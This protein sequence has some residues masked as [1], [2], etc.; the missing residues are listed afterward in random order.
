MTDGTPEALTAKGMAKD[1][2]A[3]VVFLLGTA[4]IEYIKRHFQV[5]SGFTGT[6][7]LLSELTLMGFAAG[8]ALRAANYL[9][10]EFSSLAGRIA[11]DPNLPRLKAGAAWALGVPL[12]GLRAIL[13]YVVIAFAGII[14]AL[15]IWAVLLGHVAPLWHRAVPVPGKARRLPRYTEVHGARGARTPDAAWKPDC[16]C[17]SPRSCD[18]GMADSWSLVFR[19]APMATCP[20][21]SAFL[22]AITIYNIGNGKSFVSF[23]DCRRQVG[24]VELMSR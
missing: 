7:L 8:N 10:G 21:L 11:N 9:W 12:R 22:Q 17:H 5:E 4:L 2:A 20:R 15:I 13:T 24:L 1:V 3:S 18:L 16:F 6:F 19:P 23:A 14:G